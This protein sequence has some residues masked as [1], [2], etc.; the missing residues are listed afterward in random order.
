MDLVRSALPILGYRCHVK[1]SVYIRSKPTSTYFHHSPKMVF[2]NSEISNSQRMASLFISYVQFHFQ[3]CLFRQ[4]NQQI[5]ENTD[6]NNR[7]ARRPQRSSPSYIMHH[8][9]QETV[10]L[11][12][13]DPSRLKAV[14]TLAVSLSLQSDAYIFIYNI[15]ICKKTVIYYI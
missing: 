14:Y 12:Q 5:K 6:R 3:P 1:I 4:T 7:R 2:I 8:D 11:V 9:L 10:A 13:R 15:H